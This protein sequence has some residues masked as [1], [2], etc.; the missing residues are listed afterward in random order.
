MGN[1]PAATVLSAILGFF[2]LTTCLFLGSI[3]PAFA[4]DRTLRVGFPL[5]PG[6]TEVDANNHYNGYSYEYLQEIAQYTG[7]DYEFVQL[8]G[9][10]NEVLATMV[11]MLQRGE[12]DLLGGMVYNDQLAQ[13][14][15]FPNDNYGTAYTVLGVLEE[16][17]AINTINFQSLH[18]LRIAVLKTATKRNAEVQVFCQKNGITPTFIPCADEEEQVEAL[19]E[20]RADVLVGIDLLQYPGIRTVARFNP[21]PYYLA[22]T[23]GN[24][25]I[26]NQI[27]MAMLKINETDPYLTSRLYEKYFNNQPPKLYLSDTEKAYIQKKK[28]V[29]I[30]LESPIMPF[31]DYDDNTN[32]YIGITPDL[33]HQIT[34]NTG[35]QFTFVP[36]TEYSQLKELLQNKEVDAVAGFQYDYDLAQDYYVALTR[37]YLSSPTVMI[38]NKNIKNT[39]LK[40]K[41]LALSPD[42]PVQNKYGSQV[43]F[44]PTVQ[45]CLKAVQYGQ[46]DYSYGNAYAVQYYANQAVYRHISLIPQ[47]DIIQHL[48]F[49]LAK[50]VDQNL[51]SIFNKAIN[52][53][54]DYTMQGIIYSNTMNARK[55]ITF[56]AFIAANPNALAIFSLLALL[57][58][59]VLLWNL[60]GRIKINRR[61]ALEHE[62][63]IQL[64]ELSNEYLFEYDFQKNRLLMSEK[65]AQKF[66]G[67]P[68]QA[69]DAENVCKDQ[70]SAAEIEQQI[71][72]QIKDQKDGTKDFCCQLADGSSRWLRI[73][74]KIIPDA[75][76]KP[77]YCVGKVTDIQQEIEEKDALLEQA[78][79]DSLTGLY[80]A[81]TSRELVTNC[82]AQRPLVPGAMLIIDIDHFKEINDHLGHYA[83]D[84]VLVQTAK[85]FQENFQETD[86]I[87]RLGGDEFMIFIYPLANHT[88]IAPKCQKLLQ[89]AK[90]KI[91][92]QN[93]H[94]LTFSIGIALTEEN[95]NFEDLYQKADLALY[96]AKK[97]G[98]N[99]FVLAE[100][101]TPDAD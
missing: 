3:A 98:R 40:D 60:H 84:Q 53:I 20:N 35:L 73:T 74:V 68:E 11:D 8:P 47:P 69:P 67:Q 13:V 61:I 43:I 45:D 25:D 33:L 77:V 34:Q 52:S 4:A 21:Q 65:N 91:L 12:L 89:E 28:T 62:R 96:E 19:Q 55:E 22:T 48:C 71:L 50:P 15:D 92:L 10:L 41:T 85:L 81:A 6:L 99:S 54:P 9:D 46:A 58:I 49:G 80:N 70:G 88:I 82:L 36:F 64:S 18:T 95:Q 16:N 83:G 79:R 17:T 59:C 87:G 1:K 7:W 94:P 5:Q 51:L 38:I 26:I 44:F 23:K 101:K 14:F 90:E 56:S 93:H 2:L 78:R 66:N 29:R 30:A 97:Q 24:T 37:P 86:I 100:E 57:V 39:N 42:Y 32:T 63:Y 27:N 76:N 75:N 31:Q 72:N